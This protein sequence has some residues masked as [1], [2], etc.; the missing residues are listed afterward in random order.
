MHK[1]CK[2]HM[3]LWYLWWTK[4]I[5]PQT[6]H[7]E[8]PT[9]GAKET[10]LF[11]HWIRP[12]LSSL[13]TPNLPRASRTTSA[14]FAQDLQI[15]SILEHQAPKKL[16]DLSWG[17]FITNPESF[18]GYIGCRNNLPFH[19]AES[20]ISPCIVFFFGGGR[21]SNFWVSNCS[22]REYGLMLKRVKRQA[23]PQKTNRR[24]KNIP[25][26]LRVTFFKTQTICLFQAVHLWSWRVCDWSLLFGLSKQNI[27]RLKRFKTR[28]MA[29]ECREP[30]H[31]GTPPSDGS[32]KRL[33]CVAFH[34][35]LSSQR[36]D[37]YKMFEDKHATCNCFSSLSSW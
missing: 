11:H 17:I 15:L 37:I 35:N 33:L 2:Q 18:G 25:W 36:N 9:F 1:R 31:W 14:G 27:N 16:P 19:F 29:D 6:F 8:Q 22:T 26:D 24:K 5:R 21:V 4:I 10:R 20:A 32:S 30:K 28:E 7:L 23:G 12:G 13:V 3:A 34:H